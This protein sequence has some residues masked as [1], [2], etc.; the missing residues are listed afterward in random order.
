[1]HCGINTILNANKSNLLCEFD[2]R[3]ERSGT[4]AHT[5]R[6]NDARMWSSH[7][8]TKTL[9]TEQERRY[10]SLHQAVDTDA[11]NVTN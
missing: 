5:V 1:M 11:F 9:G 2:V 3:E 4:Y 10:P 8:Q 6:V 7:T